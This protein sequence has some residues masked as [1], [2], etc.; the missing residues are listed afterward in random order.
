MTWGGALA[1]KFCRGGRIT[2]L[3]ALPVVVTRHPALVT[4]LREEGLIPEDCPVL[5]HVS[6][7][8]VRGRHVIGV[9]PLHLAASA[10]RVTE[11]PLDVPLEWRGQELTLAQ[12]RAC[13]GKPR[14]Y[15]V[16]VLR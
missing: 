8:D 6:E 10:A 15:R 16:K 5:E 7:E 12:V 13:A 11:V 9:L 3:P 14:T 1:E 4:Y 2:R